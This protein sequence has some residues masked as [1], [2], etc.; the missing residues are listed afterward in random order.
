MKK[1][2][3]TAQY[4]IRNHHQHISLLSPSLDMHVHLINKFSVNNNRPLKSETLRCSIAVWRHV[5]SISDIFMTTTFLKM[6]KFEIFS[7]LSGFV[8]ARSLL[9]CV[10][11]Y[12]SLFVLLSYFFWPLCCLSFFKLRILITP[13]V[14]SNPS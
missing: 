7:R 5:N 13:L 3:W 9:F 10:V 12:S 4:I 14:S 8:F 2:K 11:F 6:L 1:L